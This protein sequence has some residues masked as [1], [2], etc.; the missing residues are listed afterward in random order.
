MIRARLLRPLMPIRQNYH[1]S[2]ERSSRNLLWEP[3]WEQAP[4]LFNQ[5]LSKLQNKAQFL[6]SAYV[7]QLICGT[8]VV[9]CIVSFLTFQITP[10]PSTSST[11][12]TIL[13]LPQET[14]SQVEPSPNKKLKVS[15]SILYVA[16]ILK[17]F[18][19]FPRK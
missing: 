9:D 5:Y 14:G 13:E 1:S 11:A 16:C 3:L 10:L 15:L 18:I 19:S 12:T 2:G 17:R 7:F 4:F 8:Y 6:Y